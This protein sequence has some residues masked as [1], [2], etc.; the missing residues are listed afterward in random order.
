MHVNYDIYTTVQYYLMKSRRM[1]CAGHVGSMREECI[2]GFK[3]KPEV[4]RF[5]RRPRLR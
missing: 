1:R 2:Q 5:L 4:E 3:G